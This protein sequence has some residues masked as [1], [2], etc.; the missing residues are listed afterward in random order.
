MARCVESAQTEGD[1]QPYGEPWILRRRQDC[2][3]DDAQVER[4]RDRSC[5]RCLDIDIPRRRADARER[6]SLWTNARTH[7]RT[8]PRVAC[9]AYHWRC[10]GTVG[11]PAPYTRTDA[12][13]RNGPVRLY[14]TMIVTLSHILLKSN[15]DSVLLKR[16]AAAMS[17][18]SR[19]RYRE[20]CT[21]ALAPSTHGP[22]DRRASPRPTTDA[23]RGRTSISVTALT[24]RRTES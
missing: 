24:P 10:S 21:T 5:P 22:D 13:P 15:K 17:W 3:Q 12:P 7:P 4:A 8:P 18:K 9:I 23:T 14:R 19:K 1:P 2:V 6:L 16:I 20:C 11:A